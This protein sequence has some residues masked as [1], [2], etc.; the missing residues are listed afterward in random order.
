MII[1]D[2][3]IGSGSVISRTTVGGAFNSRVGDQ[4]RLLD[5]ILDRAV[6]LDVETLILLGDCWH[7]PKPH[8]SLIAMFIGWIKKCQAHGIN[9]K[10]ILGNHDTL[11]S[12]SNFI[13]SLDIIEEMDLDGVNVYK[14]VNTIFIGTTAFT[15]LPFRDRKCFSVESNAEALDVVRNGLIYELSG[16]PP[17][18]NKVLIG[19][20][21][22]EGSIPVGDEI[23]DITNELF[24]S[25]D[26]LK[27]YDFAWLGHIH[28]PQVMQKSPHIAHIGSI[29]VSNFGET[30]QSKHIVIFDCN[31]RTNQ[32]VVEELPTRPLRKVSITVP[33]DTEDTT[34]FVLDEI[35]KA[36]ASYSQAIVRV[37]I[38]L[39]VPELKSVNKSQIEK[40][41]TQQGA[42]NVTGISESKKVALIKKNK[43]GASIDTKMD[44]PTAIK[45]FA[46]KHVEEAM[47]ADYIEEAMEIHKEFLASGKGGN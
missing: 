2:L 1:G 5:H 19:H 22:I 30:R 20:M 4:I 12:G 47:R 43:D 3:H 26:M 18:Y 8:P 27:G 15:L 11:R 10:I 24:L 40:F 36:N 35:K 31:A 25:L 39:E 6:E 33:K 28:A 44:V 17:T 45:A 9:I 42:F 32:F 23:D 13:S 41:L 7:D 21:A 46:E 37:E 16:I 38:S 34:A 29:D 14:N